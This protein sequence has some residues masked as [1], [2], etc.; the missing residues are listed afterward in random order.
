MT[1]KSMKVGEEGRF[2]KLVKST[3]KK[4]KVSNPKTGTVKGKKRAS[5]AKKK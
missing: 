4:G 2:S 1:K 3:S 5:K